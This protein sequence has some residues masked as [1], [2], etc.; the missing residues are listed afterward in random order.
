MDKSIAYP[1]L[2]RSQGI[3][4]TL[5]IRDHATAKKLVTLT[6]EMSTKYRH[7]RIL[8]KPKKA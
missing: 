8:H 5:Y 6:L 4:S 1:V 7:V 2:S 3:A